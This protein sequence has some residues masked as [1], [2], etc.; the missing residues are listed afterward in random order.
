MMDLFA[1]TATKSFQ[2]YYFFSPK[3]HELGGRYLPVSMGQSRCLLLKLVLASRI[4]NRVMQSSYLRMTS[5]VKVTRRGAVFRYSKS[6]YERAKRAICFLESPEATSREKVSQECT[7]S[8]LDV[9][10]RR[11]SR[12]SSEREA[13]QKEQ[14]LECCNVYNIHQ[15]HC[16]RVNGFSW[17]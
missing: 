11:L 3:G 17:D 10:V 13:F 16:T 15:H 2:F 4:L 8:L 6:R 14:R 1:D 7:D 9:H 12:T 5:S